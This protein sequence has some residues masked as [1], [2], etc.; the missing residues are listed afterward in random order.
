MKKRKQTG[1]FASVLRSSPHFNKALLAIIVLAAIG[2]GFWLFQSRAAT[3]NAPLGSTATCGARVST[4]NYQRLYDRT[5]PWN[6]PVCTMKKYAYSDDYRDRLW[7][8][9]LAPR[10]ANASEVANQEAAKGKFGTMF[11]FNE[12]IDYSTPVYRASDPVNGATTT[13]KIQICT[14]PQCIASNLDSTDYN[15]QYGQNKGFFPDTPIPW[16]PAWQTAKAKDKEMVIIDDRDPNYPKEYGL[17]GAF[18][19]QVE[20]FAQ[21]GFDSFSLERTRLC[22]Y[23][24]SVTREKNGTIANLNTS[25]TLSGGRGMGIQGAPMVVT[26]EEVAQGEIRS[27]LYMEAFNTMTGPACSA[28]QM[29]TNDYINVIGKVCGFAVAPATQ[30]EWKNALDVSRSNGAGGPNCT[31]SISRLDYRT[32]KSLVDRVRLPQQVPS[33]MRFAITNTDA[34]ID[35]WLDTKGYSAAKRKTAKII[36]VALRDYGWFVGD[37]TCDGA[38]LSFAGVANPETKKKWANLGIT[39]VSAESLLDGLFE[40]TK[41]YAVDPS[42]NQCVD[43][44]KSNFACEAVT[45]FYPNITSA[46]TQTVATATPT[47]TPTPKPA[48]PTPTPT[49]KPATPTPTPVPTATPAMSSAPATPKDLRTSLSFNWVMGQYFMS[50]GWTAV[51]DAQGQPVTYELLKNGKDTIIPNAPT[52]NGYGEYNVKPDVLYSYQVRSKDSAGR[53][54]A[55]SP[56]VNATMRCLWIFCGLQ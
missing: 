34:E 25:K 42:Q 36:A 12:S 48:T 39:D 19:N 24:A 52:F 6:V 33:G 26:P 16:N 38:I 29:A 7:G 37:T 31:D 54:S 41:I 20:G 1:S 40:R 35:K 50:V 28:A 56:T 46:S 15:V 51:K 22:A 13:I 30:H 10:A 11:G 49:P 17:W 43:G 4:Y 14:Q 44:S 47:P 45:S 3:N 18:T 55:Y 53:Y 27:A 32:G 5:M 8:Y 21:C 23:S 2:L 9:A